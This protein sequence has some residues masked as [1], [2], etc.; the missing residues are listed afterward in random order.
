MNILRVLFLISPLLGL[1][2]AQEPPAKRPPIEKLRL[3][4]VSQHDKGMLGTYVDENGNS[5]LIWESKV[6][7]DE[8][9]RMREILQPIQPVTKVIDAAISKLREG[10]ELSAE[11]VEQCKVEHGVYAAKLSEKYPLVGN[12]KFSR[13]DQLQCYS[14]L[15]RMAIIDPKNHGGWPIRST[16]REMVWKEYKKLTNDSKDSFVHFCA[17]FSY[18]SQNQL[19]L[20]IQSAKFVQQHDPFLYEKTLAWAKLLPES[21]IKTKFMDMTQAK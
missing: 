19:E 12:T 14:V 5:Y 17:I 16:L 11:E 6:D 7:K 18:L 9:K 21:E 15:I 3:E 2:S 4:S 13:P 1:V 20:A 10:Q 8:V